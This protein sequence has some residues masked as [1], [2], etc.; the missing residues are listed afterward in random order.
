MARNY[1]NEC[2][3]SAGSSG[4]VDQLLTERGRQEKLEVVLEPPFVLGVVARLA[5]V[6]QL[7]QKGVQS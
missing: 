4:Q 1:V 7:I 2:V 5:E 3:D 6:P